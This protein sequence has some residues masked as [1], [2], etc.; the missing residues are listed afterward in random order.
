MK[1]GDSY[2]CF[3][4]SLC[5]NPRFT[6]PTQQTYANILEITKVDKAEVRGAVEVFATGRGSNLCFCG[7][8]D[9]YKKWG[10]SLPKCECKQARINGNCSKPPRTPAARSI[11]ASIKASK[12]KLRP[13]ACFLSRKRIWLA[14][15]S[16]IISDVSP[17]IRVL[18]RSRRA[19]QTWRVQPES[20]PDHAEYSCRVA[21]TTIIPPNIVRTRSAGSSALPHPKILFRT[22]TWTGSSVGS[23]ECRRSSL[24]EFRN[25]TSF[26]NVRPPTLYSTLLWLLFWQVLHARNFSQAAKPETLHSS[27]TKSPSATSHLTCDVIRTIFESTPTSAQERPQ[28]PV[29]DNPCTEYAAPGQ[30][31]AYW[32]VCATR[33][34][35]M[36]NLPQAL[37]HL[38]RAFA[39]SI[40]LPSGMSH[41][42]G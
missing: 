35:D 26:S 3:Q 37:P 25:V 1:K 18:C 33:R 8:T 11:V 42:H 9:H 31:V 32:Q 39:S 4:R 28:H 14:V 17:A 12:D 41:S 6:Q 24:Q 40:F 16:A 38:L 7:G 21:W 34:L 23:T 20:M 27:H 10:I 30:A 29:Q 2:L 36:G 19:F 15:D 5:I 13:T 22:W